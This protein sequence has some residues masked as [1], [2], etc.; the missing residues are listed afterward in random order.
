E[1]DIENHKYCNDDGIWQEK[2]YCNSCPQDSDCERK[3]EFKNNG[4]C[5]KYLGENILKNFND[6]KKDLIVPGVI[7]LIVGL[8]GVIIF[9]GL[10]KQLFMKVFYWVKYKV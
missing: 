3:E 10:N 9:I 2:D 8:L 4:I 1:C 6:C 5:E 7:V